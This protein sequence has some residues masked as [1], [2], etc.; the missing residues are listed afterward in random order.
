MDLGLS[1][2]AAAAT[3]SLVNAINLAPVAT[4][5]WGE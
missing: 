3:T 1:G 5:R 2:K 4:E